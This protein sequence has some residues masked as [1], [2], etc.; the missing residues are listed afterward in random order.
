MKTKAL[1]INKQRNKQTSRG[2]E[3]RGG[4]K[5]GWRKKLW[6]GKGRVAGGGVVEHTLL[7]V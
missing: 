2:A 1:Q 4:G 3:W 6:L 7:Q 5:E